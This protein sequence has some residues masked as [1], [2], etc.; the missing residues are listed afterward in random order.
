MDN[1]VLSASDILK[2]YGGVDRNM[3]KNL[4]DAYEHDT[5]E[6]DIIQNSL[7]YSINSLPKTIRTDAGN[8]TIL[9]LN[10]DSLL[11]KIEELRIIIAVFGY[12][13]IYIDVICI[14][15]SHLD[16]T[17]DSKSALIQI[18]GYDCIP[19]GKYCGNK[20]GLVTY[21]RDKHE[22]EKIELMIEKDAT[23]NL[24]SL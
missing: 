19:Q 8:F 6:L 10:T 5:N 7:Y 2:E 21:V 24:R 22:L 1:N 9:C 23:N 18:T 4:L 14:Q 3:L 12:Q 17:Y 20:G 11:S 13:G 15:E 16:D